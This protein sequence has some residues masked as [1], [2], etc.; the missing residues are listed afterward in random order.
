M[1]FGFGRGS[2]FGRGLRWRFYPDLP[3]RYPMYPQ[4]PY[5]EFYYPSYMA[6]VTPEKSLEDEKAYLENMVKHLKEE[7]RMVQDRLQEL[8]KGKAKE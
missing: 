2:G 4:E 5:H 7:I 6:S 3:Y 8:S 1:G